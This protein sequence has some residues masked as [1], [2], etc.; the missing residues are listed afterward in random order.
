VGHLAEHA[1][2]SRKRETEPAHTGQAALISLHIDNAQPTL[3]GVWPSDRF[4]A[5]AQ[6]G[7]RLNRIQ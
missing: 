6:L 5:L 4:G 7:E 2:R 3:A 1:C